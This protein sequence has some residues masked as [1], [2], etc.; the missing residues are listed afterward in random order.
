MQVEI[1]KL[2]GF[3]AKKAGGSKNWYK[4]QTLH[5]K[6]K[7]YKRKSKEYQDLLNKAYKCLFNQN[8]NFRKALT[9]TGNATLKHT[10]GKSNQSETILTKR[11]F[12]S[13]LMKLRS[14][15]HDGPELF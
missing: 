8:E 11:E 7:A 14:Q 9:V 1:C 5:W 10:I 15:L 6:G 3:G 2:V 4:T 13:R 12:C